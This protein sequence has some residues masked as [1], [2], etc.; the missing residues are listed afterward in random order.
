MPTLTI[1]DETT[2]GERRP[3]ISLDLLTDRITVR[4]L[5]R[6]RVY[7]EV[8]EFNLRQPE[9]FRGLVQPTEAERVLN[10]FKLKKARKIDWEKQAEKA[11]QAFL[12]RG[13]LILVDDHQVDSLDEEI[14]IGLKTEVSFLRLVPLVGG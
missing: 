4:E 1:F 12:K 10:G 11:E 5:I 7:E 13:F 3:G 8:Q 9:V 2:A 6:K 14:E